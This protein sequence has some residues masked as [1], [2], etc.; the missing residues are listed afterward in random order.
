MRVVVTTG[1][2]VM[3]VEIDAA[4]NARVTYQGMTRKTTIQGDW[5]S[6]DGA[7]LHPNPGY[8]LDLVIQSDQ[9]DLEVAL[10]EAA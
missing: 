7:Y 8:L 3:R 5:I 2:G 4:V 6:Q 10:V 9:G 1:L